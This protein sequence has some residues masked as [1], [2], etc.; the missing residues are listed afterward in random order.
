MRDRYPDPADRPFAVGAVSPTEL[1]D[2]AIAARELAYTPYSGFSV[3]AA[4]L[5]A[6]GSIYTGCNIE[7]AAFSPTACAERVAVFSAIADGRR[8][9]R[10]I[11]VVGGRAGE[12][13]GYVTPC[14][15]CRQVL[16]E[17]CDE[18]M[19]VILLNR[20][21]PEILTLGG[22]LPLSFTL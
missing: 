9:F 10:A 20:G 21:E 2:R 8:D 1:L 13:P 17:F 16:A 4:L 6:D 12:A 5:C 15:V 3:G 18:D 7:N 19:Q 22:L 11:A 14:G